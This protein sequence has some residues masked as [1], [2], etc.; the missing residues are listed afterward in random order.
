[1]SVPVKRSIDAPLTEDDQSRTSVKSCAASRAPKRLSLR[2]VAI[3]RAARDDERI[4]VGGNVDRVRAVGN[5]VGGERRAE[6]AAGA[7]PRVLAGD[8]DVRLGEWLALLV[9]HGA[10]ERPSVGATGN[11]SSA[12]GATSVL[13][14]VEAK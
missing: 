5:G 11:E 8:P 3:A 7:R 2:V 9:A 1:M 13:P 4:G 10:A 12:T 14:S 6:L